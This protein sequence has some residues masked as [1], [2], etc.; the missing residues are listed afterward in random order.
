ML[1][2]IGGYLI[3]EII[4]IFLLYIME[5]PNPD[6][7]IF[8]NGL[9]KNKTENDIVNVILK[10]IV[11]LGEDLKRYKFD[12][13]FLLYICN[14]VEHLVGSN[15]FDKKKLV[16]SVVGSIFNLNLN[17]TE[18]ISN[19]IEFLHSNQLIKK[20]EIKTENGFIKKM[21]TIF[22]LGEKKSL[23]EK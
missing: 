1:I 12:G 6:L 3:K 2:I 4:K 7:V 9:H 10:K 18:V 17:E 8:K 22:N 20:V 14:L 5:L 15:K 16:L 13:E 11:L 19:L 23:L 21:N